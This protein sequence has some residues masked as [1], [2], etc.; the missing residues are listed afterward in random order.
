M[1]L[2]AHV[3]NSGP[4]DET[5][6]IKYIKYDNFDEAEVAHKFGPLPLP[7]RIIP[8]VRLTDPTISDP[9][10]ERLGNMLTTV[11]PTQVT[12]VQQ[13]VAIPQEEQDAVTER[14]Q[15]KAAYDSLM[16]DTATATQVKRILARL[17]KD[18]Y[19]D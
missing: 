18:Q 7:I 3:L 4:Q 12:R 16:D 5:A 15:A 9:A 1:A 10:T 14:E 13:I 17:L 6:I 8:V 19:G 2:Y 11:E